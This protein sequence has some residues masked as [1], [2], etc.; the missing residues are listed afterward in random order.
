MLR[1]VQSAV[2]ILCLLS[3]ATNVLAEHGRN[4]QASAVPPKVS[5]PI[6][7]S[8]TIRGLERVRQRSDGAL[9][10]S[11]RISGTGSIN[12]THVVIEDELSPGYS[13]GCINFGGNVTF[14]FTATLFTEIGGTTPCTG[15]DQTSVANT[16]TINSATLEM[17]LINSFVPQYGDRFDILNWGTLVGTFGTIDTTAATLTYPLAWDTSQL[18]VTGELIVGVQQIA[19]GDLAPWNAPDGNINGADMLIANQLVLGLRT[20]GP[21]QIAHG[22]MDL[23]AVIDLA[24]LMLIQQIVLP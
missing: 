13:P 14:S 2:A 19:D 16:L 12:T 8:H 1:R 24:D 15:H 18:H 11:G 23:D 3:V 5:A 4:N 20:A 9:V 22:D 10:A 21:L 17:V 7:F 6:T